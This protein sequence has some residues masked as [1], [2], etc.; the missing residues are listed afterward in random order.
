MKYLALLALVASF[1]LLMAQDNHFGL[2]FGTAL[3]FGSLGSSDEIFHDGYASPGFH[4]SFDA[5]Y[6]P[7]WYFGIGG[8]LNL[9]TYATD[10]DK[11]RADIIDKIRELPPVE[12]PEGVEGDLGIGNWSYI[13]LMVGPTVAIPAGSFQFNG[14]V[15]IGTCFGMPP[16]TNFKL[17]YGENTFNS[18]TNNQTVAF[19]YSVGTDILFS[20]SGSYAIKL[21]AEYFSSYS[22]STYDFEYINSS[23]DKI[24]IPSVDNDIQLRAAHITLGLA[25][26]F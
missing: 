2:S 16:V 9:S 18:Y 17:E 1:N 21:G 11:M 10:A 3:P 20:P 23:Q 6:I 13:N 15:F 22:N 24:D 12:I 14:H 7:T 26:Y 4:V 25:Y 5:N 8:S 19:A